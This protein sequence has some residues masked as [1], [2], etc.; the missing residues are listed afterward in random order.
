MALKTMEV[1]LFL[2]WKKSRGRHFETNMVASWSSGA[3]GPPGCVSFY[4]GIS[5]SKSP[6][7][8]KWL[9]KLQPSCLSYRFREEGG[10]APKM[11]HISESASCKESLWE[12]HTTLLLT[13][14]WSGLNHMVMPGNAGK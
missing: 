5:F 13:S 7:D 3:Q 6:H 9:V 12:P 14:H 4:C 10:R 1:S 11:S 2:P 8:S